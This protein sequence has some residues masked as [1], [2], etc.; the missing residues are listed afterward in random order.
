MARHF[1]DVRVRWEDETA[2]A[3]LKC[4]PVGAYLYQWLDCDPDYRD[5][6]IELKKVFEVAMLKVSTPQDRIYISEAAPRLF[7]TLETMMPMQFMSMVRHG[8]AF[9]IVDN[10]EDLG[11]YVHRNTLDFERFH[12]VF[13]SLC[14]NKN[15]PLASIEANYELLEFSLKQRLKGP[16]A[17]TIAPQRSS[18]AGY[19][20]RPDSSRRGYDQ[21]EMALEG[22]TKQARLS[23]EDYREVQRLW[24]ILDPSYDEMWKR[25]ERQERSTAVADRLH[26]ISKLRSTRQWVLSP[27]ELNFQKMTNTIT[28]GS[29]VEY[30]GQPLRTMQ[31]EEGNKNVD[32]FIRLDYEEQIGRSSNSRQVR[33]YGQI[34]RLFSHEMFPGGPTQVVVE[35]EWYADKG[36]NAISKLP[37]VQKSEVLLFPQSRLTFL[38]ECYP[39]PLAF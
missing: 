19:I 10:A 28:E 27:E 2:E 34:K 29:R 16:N 3:L 8:C 13:K 31:S 12:T 4:G 22:A 14:R 9:H 23:V 33:S 17:W 21:L 20:A 30:A 1:G 25:F 11:P 24:R 18:P 37:M 7:T 35:A 32:R 39:R 26:D 15:N 38:K 6:F 5:T 36:E